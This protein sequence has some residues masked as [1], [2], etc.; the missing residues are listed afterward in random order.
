MTWPLLEHLMSLLEL[1]ETADGASPVFPFL[2]LGLFKTMIIL[3]SS[4]ISVVIHCDDS[5]SSR[6]RVQD[7]QAEVTYIVRFLC[8]LVQVEGD[9]KLTRKA[10]STEVALHWVQTPAENPENNSVES[11]RNVD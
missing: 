2:S 9:E 4:M 6:R 3:T 8:K 11:P 1:D 5:L 7:R 10:L